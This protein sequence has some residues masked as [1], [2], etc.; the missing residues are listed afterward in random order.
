MEGSSGS[1][2]ILHRGHKNKI[3]AQDGVGSS[4][5]CLVC[6]SN[7]SPPPSPSSGIV[8]D[9]G[10]ELL[11]LPAQILQLPPNSQ[12]NGAGEAINSTKDK[13]FDGGDGEA[14]N[15]FGR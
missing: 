10:W 4:I 2:Q 5:P 9:V 14:G 12:K 15:G 7:L 6:S 8:S 3:L 1:G 13:E 11:L